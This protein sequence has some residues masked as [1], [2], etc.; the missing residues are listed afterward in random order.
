MRYGPQALASRGGHKLL[1]DADFYLGCPAASLA[2]VRLRNNKLN[3]PRFGAAVG[4]TDGSV[5]LLAPVDERVY[6]RLYAL[7]VC[8]IA[9]CVCSS[10]CCCC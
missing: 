7:Q 6:R 1:C 8:A 3:A 5:S 2:P 9:E 4:G 10:V